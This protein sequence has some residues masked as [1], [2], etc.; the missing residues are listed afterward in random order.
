MK[1]G[2]QNKLLQKFNVSVA[3]LSLVLSGKRNLQF[4]MA[5]RLA[6][7]TGSDFTIW[8]NGGGTPEE[9]QAAVEAWAA[10]QGDEQTGIADNDHGETK[11]ACI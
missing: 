6:E 4:S 11:D 1:Q 10:K 9:R 2:Y 8:L 3:T 5:K 7:I